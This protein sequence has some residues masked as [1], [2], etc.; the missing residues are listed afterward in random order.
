V[1]L[2]GWKLAW[3]GLLLSVGISDPYPELRP[4]RNDFSG[5][6]VR[7]DQ[8][9]RRGELTPQ[10]MSVRQSAA[11]MS[12]TTQS[13]EGVRERRYRFG[14]GGESGEESASLRGTLLTLTSRADSGSQQWSLSDDA[15]GL[16]VIER[17]AAG[18]VVHSYRRAKE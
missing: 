14:N 18:K 6:W 15:T 5:E 7:F 2:P 9:P 17:T 4:K 12:V 10:R 13:P 16:T 8:R 1:A 3:R 11:D